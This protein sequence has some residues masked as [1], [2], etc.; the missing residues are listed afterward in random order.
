MR[1]SRICE[2]LS[3][4]EPVLISVLHLM[5]ASLFEM[6][7]LMGFDGIW[8]DLEHHAH[9]VETAQAMM[10]AARVGTSDVMV[11]PAKGE[12]MR[13][14]RLLEAGAQGI[15]YPRC[16]D[17]REAS[18]LVKWSKFPPMGARGFDGSGADNP[19]CFSA[20]KDYTEHANRHTFV[21]VQIEDPKALEN[22]DEIAAVEGVD[23]VFLGP[24][25]FSSMAGYPGQV[26]HPVVRE[27]EKVI[28]AAVAKHGKHWGRPVASKQ[29]AERL[30]DMGA[31]FL[32]HGS[33][34]V[35]IK[36]GFE[37]IQE[38]FR[39]LGVTFGNCLGESPAAATI[40]QPHY[41]S[42]EKP[43]TVRSKA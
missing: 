38:E 29:E 3:R 32:A 28:A 19:F 30:M 15:L 31:R 27:A 12:L 8:I 34:I 33:D 40:S 42:V 9:S 14:G 2:K 25:D 23:V 22:V 18:E 20:P 10:R 6:I 39:S 35:L 37:Q 36:H 17:A 7:S 21:A 13:T 24:A 41:M 11:R 26:D 43:T 4:N 16:D 5:D 1:N